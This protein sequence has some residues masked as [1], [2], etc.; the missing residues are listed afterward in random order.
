MFPDIWGALIAS[1]QLVGDVLRQDADL[2]GHLG[3]VDLF[4]SSVGV[5]AL[6]LLS[7]GVGQ[8]GVLFLNRVRGV[9]AVVSGGLA[10]A[11]LIGLR[12][13]EALV[14]WGVALAVTRRP[15]PL[16]TI[17]TVFLLSLAPHVF[18][19]LTFLPF[20]GLG[21]ARVL[22]LWSFLVLFVLLGA[23]YA[24]P[25]WLALLIALS[26]WL[27]MQLLARLLAA[28]LG[29]V[30]SRLWTLATGEPVIVT[31][32]NILTGGPYVPDAASAPG[33]GDS[34]PAAGGR[35]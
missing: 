7:I 10:L 12:L 30:S 18:N 16:M 21:I 33:H 4:W 23:A 19:A 25:G 13:M 27:L 3:S 32:A 1:L 6:A 15:L 35:A 8:S 31:G 2:P 11:L 20:V 29:W 28:P 24:L 5:A 26:G 9:R 34:E 17:L 14:T 22:E